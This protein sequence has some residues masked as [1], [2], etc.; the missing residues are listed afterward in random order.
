M[1]PELH[2]PHRSVTFTQPRE[3]LLILSHK[4][5]STASTTSTRLMAR[6]RSW[7]EA[8]ATSEVGAHEGKVGAHEGNNE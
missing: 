7:F 8:E 6:E 2:R 3:A 5:L 4:A 1:A